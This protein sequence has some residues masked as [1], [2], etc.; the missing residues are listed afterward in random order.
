[1]K[2]QFL[3]LAFVISTIVSLAQ[4]PTKLA[5]TQ[6]ANFA[7]TESGLNTAALKAATDLDCCWTD[8]CKCSD[9]KDP[10]EAKGLSFDKQ[11]DSVIKDKKATRTQK[12]LAAFEKA[13]L[14]GKGKKKL[15]AKHLKAAFDKHPGYSKEAMSKRFDIY[16][17]SLESETEDE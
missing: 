2:K 13:I 7:N 16:I 11:M 15:S 9:L 14:E 17:L 12:S 5:K 1:M 4:T 10:W 8:T 3:T 6:S